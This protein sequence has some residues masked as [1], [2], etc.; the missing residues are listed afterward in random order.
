MSGGV[1]GPAG[2]GMMRAC[3]NHT[4][5]QNIYPIVRKSILRRD[6]IRTDR[7]L[8]SRQSQAIDSFPHEGDRQEIAAA[9]ERESHERVWRVI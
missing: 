8:P 7:S 4:T 9:G 5:K 1:D 3:R 2:V 6:A